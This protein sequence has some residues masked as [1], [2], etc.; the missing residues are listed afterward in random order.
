MSWRNIYF[1]KGANENLNIDIILLGEA[2]VKECRDYFNERIYLYS[3]V[4]VFLW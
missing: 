1:P 2:E 4:F 3:A